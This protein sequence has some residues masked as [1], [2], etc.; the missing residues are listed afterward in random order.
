MK[1][2]YSHYSI[3][4]IALVGLAVTG[5]RK[6]DT[7]T[8]TTPTTGTDPVVVVDAS[9][10]AITS[11]KLEV[12]NNTGKITEDITCTI[13]AKNE[14]VAVIP[15]L[16]AI[17]KLVLTFTTKAASTTV[18]NKDT[19]QVSGTTLTDYT[20][21]VTYT[22][23]AADGSTKTYKVMVK[24]FTGLPILNLTTSG[25]VDSKE[26]YVKGSLT[27]NPNVEFEQTVTKIPLQIK[28]RG[29]S[30]WV[31]YPKK[32][33]RLKFD[34]KTAMLGMPAA[35]N[36]V[37]LANYNDKTLMRNR[38]ALML[39]KRLG[40]D[41]TAD[42]RFVEVF[43]NG[44]F[45]GN[46]LL[47]SQ[48]E[49]NENRVNITELKPA[50]TSAS[51]ITGGYL[52]ELDVKM[53]EVYMFKTKKGLPFSLKSPEDCTP[54]QLSYITNYMQA[55]EDAI[56][57]A[58]IN[59][60]V[61]GYAKYINPQSFINW[62][63]TEEIFQTTDARD[64]SSI[65]YYKDR[66]GKLGMGPVWDFDTSA[67][68][69]DYAPSKNPTG[70]WY[71]RD[72]TWMVKLSQAPTFNAMVKQRWAAIKDNEVKQIYAN[73]D[74]TAA[75][76][77]LSQAQNF[78]KWPILGSYV[79]PNNVVLGDYDKEVAYFKAFLSQRIA[80]MNSNIGTW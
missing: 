69:V 8:Q 34:S 39:G 76:L 40:A 37:L 5:C 50:N 78:K 70:I 66:N 42:S 53:D 27:V 21:P 9:P 75:Y 17:K 64:F 19:L 80:W 26:T 71:V 35:K 28:G 30:T 44:E 62:Y 11:A 4:I 77:K 13:N 56:Y 7:S 31:M 65:F 55:T 25:P 74:E 54:A 38:I 59:D 20:K 72:A 2:P 16:D 33:Y 43:M 48:V 49:I 46:Y 51:D 60:P 63:F 45:L 47:T 1:K 14:I 23:L 3:L 67:G 57:S 52:M 12:K 61:E 32:P 29:N 10:A 6:Y 18:K 36:W 73:I 41:W 68:N 79:Y 24:V 22:T 15:T 58:N